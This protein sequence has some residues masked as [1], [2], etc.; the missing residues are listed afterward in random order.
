MT[1]EATDE[2]T[3]KTVNESKSELSK[4]IRSSMFSDVSDDMNNSLSVLTTNV[5]KD[6]IES[7]GGSE[8]QRELTLEE[9]IASML[10]TG[11]SNSTTKTYDHESDEDDISDLLS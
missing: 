1:S 7:G 8:P 3:D 4:A 11:D 6:S 10:N 2:A 5:T 9:R